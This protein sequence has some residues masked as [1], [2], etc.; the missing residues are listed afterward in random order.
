[1][2]RQEALAKAGRSLQERHGLD[3]IPSGE[4]SE[5]AAQLSGLAERGLQP[6][7][8]CYNRYNEGTRTKDTFVRQ[9]MFIDEGGSHYKYVGAN[10]RY[11]G[12][13]WHHKKGQG[14]KRLKGEWIDGVLSF[15]DAVD[16]P[17]FPGEIDSHHKY[18][19][20]SANPVQVN[21]YE[22]NPGARKA[23]IRHWGCDCAVCGFSFITVYGEI[24]DGFI[25]VHHLLDLATIG[26]EYEVDPITDLRPVCPNCHAML[27]RTRPAMSIENLRAAVEQRAM[28]R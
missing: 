11:T 15:Y 1:M 23:C 4:L 14:A 13:V 8:F 6:T 20:G 5:L 9:A 10:H 3:P 25:H 26:E 28:R 24:G 27:H 16:V 12:L 19:E 7:D 22:R 21:A 18:V 17:T 2:N